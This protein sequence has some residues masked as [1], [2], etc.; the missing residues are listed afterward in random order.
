MPPPTSVTMSE[1]GKRILL[2]VVALA[3]GI[4]IG[5]GLALYMA[6]NILQTDMIYPGAGIVWA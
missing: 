2:V 4:A 1:R 5:M 3:A 6:L